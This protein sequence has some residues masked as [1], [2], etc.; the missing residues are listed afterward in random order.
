MKVGDKIR[1]FDFKDRNDILYI[2]RMHKFNGVV[3]TITNICDRF[4]YLDFNT[5]SFAY[6]KDEAIN[7]ELFPI[8]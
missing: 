5:A 1:G 7:Q 4:I 8:Y 2:E 3:G 6:P